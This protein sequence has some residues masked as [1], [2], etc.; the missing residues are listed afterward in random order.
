MGIESI[1]IL[2]PYY[3]YY[4]WSCYDLYQFTSGKEKLYFFN[5]YAHQCHVYLLQCLNQ[6]TGDAIIEKYYL[7]FK[8][9]SDDDF[10]RQSDELFWY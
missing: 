10:W 4:G 7:I 9:Y 8:N 3:D 2:L 6:I 1:K 5:S